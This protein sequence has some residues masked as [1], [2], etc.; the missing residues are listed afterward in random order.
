M[1]GE[2]AKLR[3]KGVMSLDEFLRQKEVREG[4]PGLPSGK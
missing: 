1:T 3:Q 4:G 2:P